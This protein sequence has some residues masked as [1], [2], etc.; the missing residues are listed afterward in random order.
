MRNLTIYVGFQTAV[1]AKATESINQMVQHMVM[2]QNRMELQQLAKFQQLM[3]IETTLESRLAASARMAGIR[4]I[5]WALIYVV[6]LELFD[7]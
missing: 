5:F 7:V 4:L 6:Y 3:D 2:E 1:I